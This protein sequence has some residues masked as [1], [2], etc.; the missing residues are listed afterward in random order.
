MAFDVRTR[1]DALRRTL[2]A[3]SALVEEHVHRSIRA[4]HERNIPAANVMISA[5]AKVDEMEIEIEE[6]CLALLQSGLQATDLRHVV[7]MLKINADLER[8][9]DLAGN[10]A[11]GV[12]EFG[13]R[14][15]FLLPPQIERMSEA[16]L[17]MLRSCLDAYTD[18]D[19]ARARAVI[20][21]DAE[22]DALNKEI[23][24]LVKSRIPH[25][26]ETAHQLINLLGIARHI[27]RIADYTT[28]IAEDVIFIVESTIVRHSKNA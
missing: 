22:V 2:L 15:N 16:M 8:I 4:M 6:Q 28:N 3:L 17:D 12:A 13:H 9:G 1:I 27:E 10:I 7:A 26:P 24:G 25:Q 14:D 20:A 21:D 11:R 18:M 19:S 23:N 5:D